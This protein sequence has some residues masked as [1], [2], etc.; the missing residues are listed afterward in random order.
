MSVYKK[1]AIVPLESVGKLQY[2][3]NSGRAVICSAL[4]AIYNPSIRGEFST[5]VWWGRGRSTMVAL[6]RSLVNVHTL[7][8]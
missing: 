6:D 2:A 8:V 7:L 4:D 1:S 3:V 5:A